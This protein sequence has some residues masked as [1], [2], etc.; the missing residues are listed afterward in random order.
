MTEQELRFVLSAN[1]EG[2]KRGIAEAEKALLGL[3]KAIL[4]IADTQL[5]YNTAAKQFVDE[6]G[7]FIST[8]AALDKAGLLTNRQ[9]QEGIR[10]IQGQIRAYDELIV[11]FKDDKVLTQQLIQRK[12]ALK[13]EYGL[14]DEAQNRTGV[15]LRKS[16]QQF[17]NAG[18]AIASFATGGVGNAINNVEFLA[19]SLGASAPL[20][21]GL[22]VV[23]AAFYVFG[24]DIAEA[25]DPIGTQMEELNGKTLELVK[26]LDED[27]PTLALFRDQIPAAIGTTQE[28]V[29]ELEVQLRGSFVDALVRAGQALAIINNVPKSITDKVINIIDSAIGTDDDIGRIAIARAR[30]ND[31]RTDQTKFEEEQLLRAELEEDK[32]IQNN[33]LRLETIRLDLQILGLTEKAKGLSEE[34]LLRLDKKA[35]IK[36][37][38][39][40]ITKDEVTETE[41]LAEKL[42]EVRRQID[43]VLGAK[44]TSIELIQQE[45]SAEQ[46]RLKRLEKIKATTDQIAEAQRITSGATG[47]RPIASPAAPP[48]STQEIADL[49]K[50]RRERASIFDSSFLQGDDA[51]EVLVKQFEEE[52]KRIL[53]AQE[54]VINGTNRTA[55]AFRVAGFDAATFYTTTRE[56]QVALQE[57]IAASVG[58]ISGSFADLF[59]GLASSAQEGGQG[60]FV[61][62][63]AFATAQAIINTYQA[64]SKALAEGGPILGPI[65]AAAAIVQGGVL[66]AKI[67]ATNP[68]SKS[69][70]GAGGAGRVSTVTALGFA[71]Q[72]PDPGRAGVSRPTGSV[73]TGA[74]RNRVQVEVIATESYTPAG[75]RLR[76]FRQALATESKKGGKGTL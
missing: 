21:A 17:R 32:L 38:I 5:K 69:V 75:D 33:Q 30:L 9:F 4:G 41:K 7:E 59:Q 71:G 35:G 44:R 42:A 12:Q 28:R 55:E 62:Y 37:I 51:N 22:A 15:G 23:S 14:L 1:D 10:V 34:E 58:S 57:T 73:A 36:G 70:S 66:V 6:S 47:V 19:A 16:A 76:S 46:E 20:L 43:L 40:E 2:L 27:R 13:S 67:A 25:L 31:L 68:G 61:A 64:A 29:N 54:G 52:Q 24:D 48:L 56:G 63:K 18:Q 11:R 65:L 50:G 45:I 72:N 49:A 3:D 74:A 60:L 53:E 26:I 8:Q 39:A